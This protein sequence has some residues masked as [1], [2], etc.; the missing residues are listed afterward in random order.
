M[1]F[2]IKVSSGPGTAGY[3]RHTAKQNAKE[4]TWAGFTIDGEAQRY[5]AQLRT[6][7]P[8]WIIRVADLEMERYQREEA[9]KAAATDKHY[10]QN[11]REEWQ[12]NA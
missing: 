2:A 5:A 4:K 1:R 6:E 9:A 3:E 12:G 7:H 10:D 8:T 11:R